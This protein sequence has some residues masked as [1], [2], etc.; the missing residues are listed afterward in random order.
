MF[1]CIY[2]YI[3][4]F[5]YFFMAALGLY[6]FLYGCT[7]LCCCTQDFS[8]CGE[9]SYSLVTVSQCSG[10]SCRAQGSVVVTCWLQGAW[11]SVAVAQG[12]ISCG[13]QA[14]EC[15]GLCSCGTWAQ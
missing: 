15:A 13:S 12:L 2:I 8:S 10:F 14:L 3:I 7:G 9:W 11:A 4:L 6:L 5:I 1:I